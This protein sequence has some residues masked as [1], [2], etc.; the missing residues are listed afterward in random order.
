MYIVQNTSV[1]FKNSKLTNDLLITCE[2]LY[3]P[4]D[5]ASAESPGCL[6]GVVPSL[7]FL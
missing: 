5:S 1:K 7:S 4:G 6:S 3:C 2:L